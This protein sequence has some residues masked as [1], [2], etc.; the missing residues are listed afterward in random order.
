MT[1]TIMILDVCNGDLT[2][3]IAKNDS[4]SEHLWLYRLMCQAYRIDVEYVQ[5]VYQ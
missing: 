1:E 3:H 2:P 5:L 4:G